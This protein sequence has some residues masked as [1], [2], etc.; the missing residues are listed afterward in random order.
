VVLWR[1]ALSCAAALLLLAVGE[2]ALLGGKAWHKVR[3]DQVVARKSAVDRIVAQAELTNRISDLVNK[4]LLPLEMLTVLV[5]VDGK[6]KP[7]DVVFT[8]IE[9]R[10][11][12]CLSRRRRKMPRRSP[13]TSPSSRR[14]PKS[15]TSA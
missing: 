11:A 12:A 14:F 5:G 1:V 15:R 2:L 3:L 9:T 10:P 7:E 13:R 4:R 6:R 8:R